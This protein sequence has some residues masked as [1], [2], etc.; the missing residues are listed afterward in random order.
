MIR[1]SL[2]PIR[3]AGLL[4]VTSA[5]GLVLTLSR[6]EQN[7]LIATLPG[8]QWAF[9][10]TFFAV[11]DTVLVRTPSHGGSLTLYAG[12]TDEQDGESGILI[13]FA[14][15]DSS[16]L[17]NYQSARLVLFR[18]TFG[19]DT[20]PDPSLAF[21]LFTI[22]SQVNDTIWTESDTAGHVK[23]DL[24]ETT[25]EGTAYLSTAPITLPGEDTTTSHTDLEYLAF[26]VDSTIFSAWRREEVANNGF[27]IRQESQGTLVGF[28]S[29]DS[30]DLSPYLALTIADTTSTGADTTITQYYP[31]TGDLSIYPPNPDNSIYSDGSLHLDHSSGIRSH[32][33]FAPYFDPDTTRI[34]TGAR[35]VLYVNHDVPPIIADQVDLQVLR[36]LQPLAEGDPTE[37]LINIL[38][39]YKESD[40]LVLNLG[41][42]VTG[43]AVGTIENYGLD[44]VVIPNNH[45]FDHLVFWGASAP[46]NLKKPRLEIIYSSLYKEVP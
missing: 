35:L 41:S 1:R 22:A 5:A 33:D 32:I 36:R 43:L 28:H 7:P 14:S 9:S 4:A 24:L 15:V 18:R 20:L 13:K 38:P 46:D 29:G 12:L 19:E 26:E 23:L 10:D 16:R 6:C 8:S 42:F 37:V 17:A 21:N 30:Y 31:P 39:C 44:L 11:V 3:W 40:S 25:P 45:D 2:S 34:V 27:L